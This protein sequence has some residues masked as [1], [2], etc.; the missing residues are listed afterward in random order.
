MRN[1]I[2]ILSIL[3]LSF[4]SNTSS[5]QVLISK[6]KSK[7]SPHASAIL[8]LDDNTSGLLLPRLSTQQMNGIK[9]PADGL[10][11]YNSTEKNVFIYKQQQNV[12]QPINING[13]QANLLEGD[14]CCEWKYDTASKK[15]YL[16][17]GLDLKDTIYYNT[18]NRKFVY[19]D[20]TTYTNSLG[21]T[22]NL[23]DFNG[24]YYFKGTASEV[25][26]D[27]NNLAPNLMNLIF[28]IDD[29]AVAKSFPQ[30]AFYNGLQLATVINPNATQQAG[31]L[32]GISNNTIHAGQDSA[33]S[34][35]GI[36]NT[37]S[38]NGQGYG[39]VITGLQ[40]NVR[41]LD[42]AKSNAIQM[43]GI[44]N[45]MLNIS[46]ISTVLGNV[47]GYF[48]SSNFQPNKIGGSHYGIFLGNVIGAAVGRNYSLYTNKGYHRFGDSVLVTDGFV[49][50]PRTVF[51][52]NSTGTMI[53]PSGSTAQRPITGIGGMFRYNNGLNTP[54]YFNGSL[55]KSLS[56]DSA[57]WK[58]D[59]ANKVFLTRGYPLGDSIYYNTTDKKFVFA[60]KEI[61]TNSLGQQFPVTTFNGKYYFKS[62]ASRFVDTLNS[63]PSNIN[64]F[65]EV[66][67]NALNENAF[68]SIQGVT[69]ANPTAN[70][71]IG[72]LAGGSFT[73][74]HAGNDTAFSVTG[75]TNSATVNGVGAASIVTGFNNSAR[76]SF[77]AQKNV[78]SIYG[79]RNSVSNLSSISRVS[80]N[81]YGYFGSISATDTLGNKTAFDGNAYGIFL[82]SINAAAPKR[83]YAFYSNKGHNRF[84]DST[85]V[86]D[87]FITQPRAVFDINSTGTMILP[88]GTSLQRPATGLT[89]MFRYNTNVVAPEYF[90]GTQWKSLNTDSAEWVFNAAT[91]RV[92]LQRGLVKNDSIFYNPT[93]RK[94]VFADRYTNTNSL[95]QDF[96]VDQFNAKY[97]FKGTAS[98]RTDTTLSDGSVTNVVYEVDN[99]TTGTFYNSLQSIAVMNPKAFQKADQLSALTTNTIHAGN[100]S[101]QQVF[102]IINTV[103]NSGN[104]KSG[105]ITG[106]NNSARIVNGN[107]NNT[108][109]IVGIRNSVGRSGATAGRVTGNVYGLFESF[110]GLANNVDGSI[111]GVY[112]NTVSGAAVKKNYAFYSNKGYNRLGDSTL[113]TDGAS[114]SPRAV[115][116]V[117]STSAMIVPTGTTAQRPVTAVQGMVRY[118]T[119]NNGLEEYNGTQWNGTIR[120]LNAIDLPNL[121]SGNGTTQS[122]TVTNATL[123][124]VV[125]V[126]P[127]AALPAGIVIA[128]S[129]VSAANTVEI[130][131]ENNSGSPVNAPLTNFQVRVMQ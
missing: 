12:W 114:I 43:V 109:E 119:T 27:T 44:R 40:N 16:V 110:T 32:R 19:T 17:R 53:L 42:S 3:L 85:L 91:N 56:T 76:V 126:S 58:F 61:Y 30:S 92:Y 6:D 48:G 33:G 79:I 67:N 60:D 5:A 96:P 83:N 93:T 66:D 4:I 74:I 69:V 34:L 124:S 94:F 90:N 22:F 102:G 125:A 87:G 65:M 81:A 55:W 89:G 107:A 108:G 113:I 105:S 10:L 31:V 73:A 2:W 97:T 49:T 29:D 47:Y 116:D 8:D 35:I 23:E 64:S 38:M 100:D 130:R 50:Q 98:Q 62:T 101:V 68:T 20:K 52:I 123:G 28:E 80:G 7:Q 78:S 117:N 51:D 84:G 24:K 11:I 41:I 21:Q 115:L 95:G 106:F 57:E 111:Y 25:V 88:V 26:K 9:K 118:N 39:G 72:S 77:N 15:V 112:L 45:S 46:P 37:T 70:Q 1:I 122:I 120:S 103:R 59:N 99:A 71:K 54:E 128:W 18:N 14:S 104:G 63:S 131:F 13:E 86:T 121:P 82:N 129:R 36:T 127:Q 75:I